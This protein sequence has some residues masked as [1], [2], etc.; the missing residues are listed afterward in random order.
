MTRRLPTLLLLATLLACSSSAGNE[1]R[2]AAD[3]D[4]SAPGEIRAVA[5]CEMLKRPQLYFDRTLRLTATYRVGV[6]ASHLRDEGCQL[7]H[8]VEVA[9][10]FVMTDE[11]QRDV[12]RRDVDK[13]MSGAYGD[14]RAGVTVVGI[15]RNAPDRGFGGYRYRFDI[16]RFEEISR[17]D[18]SRMITAYEGTLQ[19]GM[20]YRATVRGDKRFELALIPS[21]R[22]LIHQAVRV[23]WVN[24]DDFPALKRL[25][26]SSGEKQIVFKVISDD[27][28]Q[29]TERRWNRTLRCEVMLVE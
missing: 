26:N 23:E 15:L 28:K 18:D 16:M 19:A 1:I 17:E 5:F 24:L 25:R 27:I 10:K 21:V 13:I 11:R 12:I 3:Q 4:E 29:M 2:A 14:G 9:V 20:I 7:S 8:R 22:M 6:E